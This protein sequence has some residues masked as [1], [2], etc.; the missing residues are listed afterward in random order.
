MKNAHQINQIFSWGDVC[1]SGLLPN[2]MLHLYLFSTNIKKLHHTQSVSIN[3][4]SV[5]KKIQSTI[6][7]KI[8]QPPKKFHHQYSVSQNHKQFTIH[9]TSYINLTAHWPLSQQS[10]VTKTTTYLI[11]NTHNWSTGDNCIIIHLSPFLQL[12]LLLM[13]CVWASWM[14]LDKILDFAHTQFFPAQMYWL[15]HLIFC[16]YWWMK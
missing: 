11:C 6:T 14:K 4:N 16:L 3:N 9:K 7:L 8:T 5:F 15:L 12:A 2:H 10:S 13:Q 1:Y